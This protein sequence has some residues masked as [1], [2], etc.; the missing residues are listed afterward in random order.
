MLFNL[1]VKITRQQLVTI[2]NGDIASICRYENITL[3]SSIV[4]SNVLYIPQLSNNFI[5]VQ[6]LIEHLSILVIFFLLLIV[7][8][9]TLS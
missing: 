3:K 8:F 5:Y 2:A 7:C 1:Y 9:K 4:L 6:K